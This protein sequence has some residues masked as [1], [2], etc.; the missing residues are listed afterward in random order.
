MLLKSHL[1]I[2]CHSQY[3]NLRISDSFITVPPLV[4][5][6]D[7]VCVVRHLETI[8][9]LVL[10]A[11]NFIPERSHHSLTLTRSW[12]RDSAT[13]ELR[14]Y[15]TVTITPGDGKTAIKVEL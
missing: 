7:W 6:G 4:N 13:Q 1:G 11:F 14:D 15:A 12:L 3:N 10:V 2:K 5:A 8:I 9:V